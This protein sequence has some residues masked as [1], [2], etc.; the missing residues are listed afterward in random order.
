MVSRGR[1]QVKPQADG[2]F[3]I[4]DTPDMNGSTLAAELMRVLIAKEQA[5]RRRGGA[6]TERGEITRRAVKLSLRLQRMGHDMPKAREMA[7]RKYGRNANA[8]GRA[9]RK[10]RTE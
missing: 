9:E 1:A 7:A 8:V 3:L 4:V 2:S 10:L 5:N 6:L